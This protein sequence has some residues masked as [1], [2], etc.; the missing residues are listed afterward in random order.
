MKSLRIIAVLGACAFL[1][2][3]CGGGGDG[4]GGGGGTTPAQSGS[5]TLGTTSA[6]FTGVAG[7]SNPQSR[8]IALNITGSGVAS[9]GAGF[10][11]G[12]T[13][14][15]WLDVD[16]TGSGNSYQ[17]HIF[18]DTGV[19]VAGDYTASFTVSTANANDDVLQTRVVTVTAHVDPRLE[20]GVNSIQRDYQFG[21]ASRVEVVTI[22]VTAP[23]RDWTATS[24]QPWVTVPSDSHTGN[25]TT[26]AMIDITGMAPGTYTAQIRVA[27]SLSAA[28]GL[29]IPVSI[30]IAPAGFSV[31]EQSALFG[32]ENGRAALVGVPIHFSLATGQGTHPFVAT[33]STDSGGDWLTLDTT[34]GTVGASGAM[35][36][37]NASRDGLLGGTYTGELTVT[38]DVYGIQFSETLPVTFNVEARRLVV[39]AAGVGLS[40]VAA[41][42]VLTRTV[43]VFSTLGDATT[44][45]N[46]VSDSPWLSVTASGS[47][48]G[49]LTLTANPGV[50]AM[51]TTHFANVA[52]S[53]SDPS[54]ENT[55]TIR[56]GLHLT[57]NASVLTNVAEDASHLAAS[58]VEPLVA[59]SA[60]T[61][62][63]FNV[64]T[65][66][67]V[68][69]IT[70]AG[71]VPAA[72][73][74]SADGRELYVFDSTNRVVNAVDP[75][76]GALLRTYDSQPISQLGSLGHAVAVLRPNGHPIL[77]TP[78]ART[79]DLTT[80][81]QYS[82]I[83][84]A[85]NTPIAA[86][87][88]MSLASSPDQSLLIPHYGSP[89]RIT[90]TALNGGGLVSESSVV[91]VGTA[92]GR[93]GEA[94]MSAAG[95]RI[96]TASGAPYE[97]P[98]TSV[99]TGEVIQILPG[100]NYPNSM[101]CV[102]NGLVIG[103]VSGYYADQDIFI[104]NGPT[105]VARGTR[106]SDGVNTGAYRYLLERGLAVSA[107][108]T[109]LV[110]L[111]SGPSYGT[112]EGAYFHELPEP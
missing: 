41:R 101:Q 5:F 89:T 64:Y 84:S 40:R 67:L 49:E 38:T 24:T 107:D 99:E 94:C 1:L 32:G 9:V 15:G 52:V 30:T 14:V 57:A 27:T 2:Q 86:R 29:T 87:V 105:G 70:T 44:P 53:S 56:V 28:D 25:G 36:T 33:V 21:D 85:S 60:G 16:I 6:S 42:D 106:S 50:L 26:D 47:T 63:L 51:E 10:A 17:L 76:S 20:L 71:A 93:D 110:S 31:T 104:Y 108:G 75:D 54:V 90:I 19:M 11:P 74:W 34:S 96:Y 102:W 66:T 112:T 98:A 45:W 4:E 82:P 62:K 103:G 58:P 109:R 100:T 80:H 73:T 43:K 79:Y 61:V 91:T 23:N 69:E 81:T 92:Q 111:W 55:E 72:L 97:F 37:L 13:P 8:E 59:L 39:S 22:N 7:L 48:G 12:Q 77:V 88:A 18:V 68:R 95:D 46:A 35:V 3:A 78:S 65:G 83:Y